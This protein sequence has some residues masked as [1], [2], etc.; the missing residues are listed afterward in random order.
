MASPHPAHLREGAVRVLLV[1]GVDL[2]EL[3]LHLVVVEQRALAGRLDASEP[4][5]AIAA[6]HAREEAQDLRQPRQ[7]VRVV[8]VEAEAEERVRALRIGLVHSQQVLAHAHG[9]ARRL[10][11][12]LARQVEPAQHAPA[13][14]AG[15]QRPQVLRVLR[16]CLVR[17]AHGL[18]HAPEQ[19]AVACDGM[20]ALL[21]PPHRDQ[22]L[23]VGPDRVVRRALARLGQ[24]HQRLLGPSVVEQIKGLAV[25]AVL[26]AAHR[27]RRRLRGEQRRH[28]G[29]D[30]G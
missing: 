2:V 13:R 27:V 21:Q 25:R 26:R 28:H 12:L 10:A 19:L 16:E 11:P 30:H 15:Q 20:R 3:R 24:L 8:V 5:L 22:C 7:H 17:E 1:E 6:R 18:V 4:A 29:D 23:Q 14:A 9:R